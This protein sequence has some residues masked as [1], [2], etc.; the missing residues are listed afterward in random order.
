MPRFHARE[1]FEITD[2]QMFVMVGS[3][4]EGEIRRGMFVRVPLDA[5]TGIQLL[6]DSIESADRQNPEEV[7]LCIWAGSRFSEILRGMDFRNRTFQVVAETLD[8]E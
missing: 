5:K 1:T 3:I 7:H 8:S 4:V 2:R 6:I